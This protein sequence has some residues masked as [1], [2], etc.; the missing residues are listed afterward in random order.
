MPGFNRNPERQEDPYPRLTTF[1]STFIARTA[2]PTRRRSHR[3]Q[4]NR[5]PIRR[6]EART[7][8]HQQHQQPQLSRGSGRVVI[9]SRPLTQPTPS[10]PTVQESLSTLTPAAGSLAQNIQGNVWSQEALRHVSEHGFLGSN[11]SSPDSNI[12]QQTHAAPP[13]IQVTPPSDMAAN[14]WSL[15]P[16]EPESFDAASPFA[17]ANHPI[18]SQ[19]PSP[20]FSPQPVAFE[21]HPRIALLVT[22]PYG[23]PQPWHVTM[24]IQLEFSFISY[25]A[26]SNLGCTF[27]IGPPGWA[28]QGIPTPGG[29]VWPRHWVSG[30][31][32]EPGWDG[33]VFQ[34]ITTNF[35][36]LDPF[37]TQTDI[38]LGKPILNRML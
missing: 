19:Y 18:P 22:G 11:T 1:D 16:T 13:Q 4:R 12:N 35:I 38:V 31:S 5:Q 20:G 17:D 3:T 7:I 6:R 8:Q 14:T 25:R 9:G 2:P 34:R 24:H 27:E 30:V 37:W 28:S 29:L 36:V 21:D 32:I 15:I 26:A 23:R 33:A 10:L